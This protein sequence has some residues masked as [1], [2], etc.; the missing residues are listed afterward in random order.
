MNLDP[1][2]AHDPIHINGG[3]LQQAKLQAKNAAF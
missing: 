1:V 3:T 2:Q